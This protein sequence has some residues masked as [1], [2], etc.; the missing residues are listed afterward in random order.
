MECQYKGT[1]N[2]FPLIITKEMP[3]ILTE[4]AKLQEEYGCSQKES[5]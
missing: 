4:L 1:D 3:F 2:A 5:N